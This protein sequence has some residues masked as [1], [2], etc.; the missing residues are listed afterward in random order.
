MKLKLGLNLALV[1]LFLWS[2]AFAISCGDDDD[3]DDDDNDAADDDDVDDDDDD[4]SQD[5][6]DDET[7]DITPEQFCEKVAGCDQVDAYVVDGACE[8][9]AAAMTKKAL[10][11]AEQDS[12]ADFIT[13]V[14]DTAFGWAL[15]T[16]AITSITV[17]IS[18]PDFVDYY[19]NEK[20]GSPKVSPN[21]L[22]RFYYQYNDSLDCDLGG[23]K[24]WVSLNGDDYQE[25]ESLSASAKCTVSGSSYLF[26]FDLDGD[27]METATHET[28]T[29]FTD[30]NGRQSEPYRKSYRVEDHAFAIGATMDDFTLEGLAGISK[31]LDSVSLSDF[32]GDVILINSFAQW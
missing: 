18:A 2:T 28:Y 6:D 9:S 21:E 8:G 17:F 10:N 16:L 19:P 25:V 12:C 23:G 14:E 5:D 7:D 13:C 22:A 27:Y 1:L 20:S 15:D 3:D 29:V 11:C 32:S 30:V 26:G 4:N 31:G 24:I